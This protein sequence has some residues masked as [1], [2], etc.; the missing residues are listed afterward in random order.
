ML[1][2]LEKQLLLKGKRLLHQ[3]RPKKLTAQKTERKLLQS[4]SP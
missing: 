4:Q 2:N 1:N 3:P